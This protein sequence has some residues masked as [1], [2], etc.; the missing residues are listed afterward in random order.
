MACPGGCI[1]GGGQPYFAAEHTF[2]MDP[3]IIA[4]RR[5]A[6]YNIDSEK[7]I[8]K[9]HENPFIKKIYADFLGQPGSEKAHRLLH[10]HYS[11]QEPRGI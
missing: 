4:K 2:P 7:T 9:S 6:L 3:K 5:K 10:T 8:R 1:A 11:P